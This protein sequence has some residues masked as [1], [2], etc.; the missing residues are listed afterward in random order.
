MSTPLLRIGMM[1][2]PT[3]IRNLFVRALTSPPQ[4]LYP[5]FKYGM[6]IALLILVG[7][8]IALRLTLSSRHPDPN[9]VLVVPIMLLL[10]HLAYQLRWPLPLMVT[11][12]ILAWAGLIFA[13]YY[14]AHEWA[15][16]HH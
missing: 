3:A 1:T 14:V 10:N 13:A 8:A 12:R 7:S 16:L 6:L 4:I 9:G 5:A 2:F 11:L 15:E